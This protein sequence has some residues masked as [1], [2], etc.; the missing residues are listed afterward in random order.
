[1]T[2]LKQ[3][4]VIPHWR[5][6]IWPLLPTVV[7]RGR[8]TR[9]VFCWRDTKPWG[10][11]RYFSVFKQLWVPY[12]RAPGHLPRWMTL[13]NPISSWQWPGLSPAAPSP[14]LWP[15]ASWEETLQ[16]AQ[17]V[18]ALHL[19][20]SC[21]TCS[22]ESKDNPLRLIQQSGAKG[23]FPGWK[24][25]NQT[26]GVRPVF[27]TLRSRRSPGACSWTATKILSDTRNETQLCPHLWLLQ[28][29]QHR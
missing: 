29:V 21:P 25:N 16:A 26:R 9:G 17:A 5:R 2:E 24:E 23:I 18:P 4:Q 19:S 11:H 10:P 13:K 1:M 6:R 14:G 22:Q 15:C 7:A 12:V 8:H 3:I 28:T 27:P 20:A